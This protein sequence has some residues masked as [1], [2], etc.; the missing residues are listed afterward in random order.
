MITLAHSLRALTTKAAVLALGVLARGQAFDD[1]AQKQALGAC[2]AANA[3][4]IQRSAAAQLTPDLRSE[5]VTL[6]GGQ[7]IVNYAVGSMDAAELLPAPVT[8][9]AIL[10]GGAPTG[11][12]AIVTVDALGLT[13]WWVD[14]PNQAFVSAPLGTSIWAGV[15]RLRAADI[16]NNGSMDIAGLGSDRH[17]LHRLYSPLGAWSEASTVYADTIFDFQPLDWDYNAQL[18]CALL[19]GNGVIV[20]RNSGLTLASLGVGGAGD[21]LVVQR[22]AAGGYDRLACFTVANG[23]DVLFLGSRTGLEGPIPLGALDVAGAESRDLNGDGRADLAISHRSSRTVVLLLHAASGLPTYDIASASHSLVYGDSSPAPGNDTN[24]VVA[25]FDEDSDL[26]VVLPSV[27]RRALFLWTNQQIA[28]SAR[29]VQVQALGY[30]WDPETFV[31]A[32]SLELSAPSAGAF[33]PSH[34]EVVVWRHENGFAKGNSE[35][36]GHIYAPVAWGSGPQPLT[37]YVQDR[38]G[39]DPVYAIEIRPVVLNTLGS[40]VSAVGPT[41]KGAMIYS[42]D[43]FLAI[44]QFHM[45][46][47]YSITEFIETNYPADPPMHGNPTAGSNLIVAYL[48]LGD[49]P[50][51][52]DDET[53]YAHDD[54]TG[55]FGEW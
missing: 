43:A 27:D 19:T 22:A 31:G 4:A 42:S 13:R 44:E 5:L 55:P 34:V 15:T 26:D 45:V 9:F 46:P 11:C 8:D 37:V 10:P 38:A 23:S 35:A 49:L 12:D 54:Q 41:T 39:T 16:D 40:R 33:T 47:I 21:K 36:I 20:T 25:D 51:F 52:E 2:L 28:A 48:E 6:A 1:V 53:P 30:Y 50:D 32:L 7:L 17:A 18:E 24:P 3:N 29:R 14:V